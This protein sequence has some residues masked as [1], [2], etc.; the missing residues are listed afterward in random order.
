[1]TGRR[2]V[3]QMAADHWSGAAHPEALVAP[4]FTARLS[5]LVE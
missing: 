2:S 3:D 1:M 4:L 5:P